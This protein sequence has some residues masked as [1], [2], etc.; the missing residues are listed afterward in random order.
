MQATRAQQATSPTHC[1]K[2]HS[3]R[4][5]TRAWPLLARAWPL[6]LCSTFSLQT[7]LA[8][9]EPAAAAAK[10][11]RGAALRRCTAGGAALMCESPM[12]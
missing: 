12:G 11:L 9:A 10:S 4:T 7:P 8:L 5:L 1:S 3:L 6:D 2:A